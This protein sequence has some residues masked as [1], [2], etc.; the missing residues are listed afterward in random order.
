MNKSHHF[1]VS[2]NE[3]TGKWRWDYEEEEVRYV[4]GTVYNHETNGWTS[5]Y[6]GDGEYEPSEEGLIDQLKHSIWCMNLV[7]GKVDDSDE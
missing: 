1:I 4:D 7:N 6:L 5:G 2:F 3:E